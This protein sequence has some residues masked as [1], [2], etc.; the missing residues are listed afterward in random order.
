MLAFHRLVLGVSAFARSLAPLALVGAF[1]AVVAQDAPEPV[2]DPPALDASAPSDA[3]AAAG[4]LLVLLKSAAQ[5][6]FVDASTG[7][8]WLTLPTGIG[9]HEVAVRADGQQAV[10]ADYGGPTPGRT[11]T[12]LDLVGGK[13]AATLDLGEHV[14]PH[15]I[16][17]MPDGRR[18]IVTSE[19]TQHVIVVDVAT[20]AIVSKAPTKAAAS[21]ML[22]LAPDGRR[23]YTSNLMSASVSVVDLES[24]AFLAEIPTGAGCE[25]IAVRPGGREV[26]TTN[27]AAD[28]ISIIDTESLA[29]TATLP[30]AGF[31]IR[32]T[33]TP[34]G[35]R[36]LVTSAMSDELVIFDATT[37]TVLARRKVAAPPVD[38]PSTRLFGA[39]FPGAA[40]PIGV[41]VSPDGRSVFVACAQADRVFVLDL[42]SLDWRGAFVTGS[43]PDGLGWIP[44]GAPAPEPEARA[45]D[46]GSDEGEIPEDGASHGHSGDAKKSPATS[47]G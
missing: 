44:R 45:G 10:V 34:D 14:R 20:G 17:Y 3:P 38:D 21:H 6:A 18:V 16:A 26:W 19:V 8:T 13:V 2:A 1:R 37:R 11:L 9:P 22:A 5:V 15:G 41:L 43:E 47:N 35:A 29:V 7:V 39:A 25:G 46:D 12:V 32:V 23:V 42:R 40:V 30:C 4:S 24:G 33:F 31:P 28:S 27:R 36:A